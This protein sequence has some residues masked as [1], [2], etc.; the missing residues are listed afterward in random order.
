LIGMDPHANPEGSVMARR[1]AW[2]VGAVV[3]VCACFLA[4]RVWHRHPLAPAARVA[5][6]TPAARLA[7]LDRSF[8]AIKAGDSA[9][10]RD[11]WDPQYVVNDLKGD[12]QRLFAWVRDQTV[13]VPYQGEL[14]GPVGVLMDRK[15]NNLDRAVLLATLLEASGQKVRL[16][17]ARLSRDQ[18]EELLPYTASPLAPP[19]ERGDSE[20]Q[21]LKSAGWMDPAKGVAPQIVALQKRS[22]ELR[23]RSDDESRRLLKSIA[24][25]DG[26]SSWDRTRTAALDALSDFWWVQWQQADQS[27]TDLDLFAGVRRPVRRPAPVESLDLEALRAAPVHHEVVVRVI[28][29][30]WSAQGLSEHTVLEHVLRPSELIGQSVVLEF[31]PTAWM[32]ASAHPAAEDW[33]ADAL[34]QHEWGAALKVGTDVVAS[35]ALPE[36]GDPADASTQPQKGGDLGGLASDFSNTMNGPPHPRAAH[37][38][39]SAVWLEYE[40]R[41]PGAAARTYRRAVFDILGPAARAAS[42]N[43]PP[44]LADEQKI[45]RALSLTMQTRILPLVCELPPEFLAHLLARSVLGNR[46]LLAQAAGAT[47]VPH[48]SDAD[49]AEPYD[50]LY[51]LARARTEWS[52]NQGQIFLDR[53]NLLT[54][55]HF[56]AP[57]GSSVALRHA[58]DIVV[59]G[60]GVGLSAQNPFAVRVNQGVLDTNIETLSGAEDSS[61]G[62]TGDAFATQQDWP[63]FSSAGDPALET[64]RLPEDTRQ[65]IASDLQAGLEVAA[66]R[67]EVPLRGHTFS[68]WWRVDPNSGDTLGMGANGWGVEFEER[69]A[70]T[71]NS[72]LMS[73]YFSKGRFARRFAAIFST[74]YV[75]CLMPLLSQSYEHASEGEF[76][77]AAS[78][79]DPGARGPDDAGAGLLH[80]G[81]ITAALAS[82]PAECGGDA[83]VI[84]IEGAVTLPLIAIGNPKGAVLEGAAT[85]PPPPT[86]VSEMATTY[87]GTAPPCEI[88]GE[89]PPPVAD[90][91]G[92]ETQA[93]AQIP[94]EVPA[95]NGRQAYTGNPYEGAAG[96]P[97]YSP[98]FVQFELEQAPLEGAQ[99]QSDYQQ[100]VQNADAA[101]DAFVQADANY[102]QADQAYEQAVAADAGGKGGVAG[103][104]ARQAA[105]RARQQA[106]NDAWQAEINNN[107]A[108]YKA[109]VAAKSVKSA[110]AVTQYWQR[111]QVANN[112]LIQARA[113]L[114][115]A[116]ETALGA[117]CEGQYQHGTDSPQYQE[118]RQALQAYDNALNEWQNAKFAT[119]SPSES[120]PT[121]ADANAPTQQ[122]VTP[123]NNAPPP[124]QVQPAG[125]AP[126][127]AAPGSIGLDKTQPAP[128]GNSQAVPVQPSAPA[129][130]AQQAGTGTANPYAPSGLAQTLDGIIG[131]QNIVAGK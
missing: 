107:Y 2:V 59:N 117:S 33:R 87:N 79:G 1:T 47:N 90:N 108:K 131:V 19:G 68:G 101:E 67:A 4:Y 111:M 66:P 29:E 129:P 126:P 30:Q 92:G 15:G 128:A 9:A 41:V 115:S 96:Q 61:F 57:S 11:R 99:A 44:R 73:R 127:P 25:P 114:D 91:P 40:I 53:P 113:A 97:P 109:Q 45:L 35:A 116:R 28:S 58:V 10:A 77:G 7:G 80:L 120:A 74:T 105:G 18:A 39:L 70:Q 37:T 62:N 23:A 22:E 13:W 75:W 81:P 89:T 16:A 32:D 100:A 84:G 60:M 50:P 112:R 46:D 78:G 88:P 110:N 102:K 64:L 94:D 103:F 51:N 121:L 38:S 98:A 124:Q 104:E 72:T 82:S 42:K 49:A 123:P 6:A 26:V 125:G 27:W 34:G 24:A 118:Y 12:P 122:Q 130:G 52:A 3:I 106:F 69:D 36:S 54:S 5:Q 65:L 8:A 85:A 43:A 95:G 83:T 20:M 55:H 56:L 21:L 71:N 17:H 76:Q 31:W 63:S 119:A 86:P 14:R 48:L 93:A